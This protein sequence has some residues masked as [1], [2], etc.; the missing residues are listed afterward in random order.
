MDK[1]LVFILVIIFINFIS[2]RVMEHIYWMTYASREKEDEYFRHPFLEHEFLGY[3]E[4]IYF[5]PISI[6]ISCIFGFAFAFWIMLMMICRYDALNVY[7]YGFGI[8]DA[9]RRKKWWKFWRWGLKHIP[10]ELSPFYHPSEKGTQF[11]VW[12]DD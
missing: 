8:E 12:K 4:M 7:V 11:R 5:Y 3:K 2:H 10:P 6:I 1:L 9:S